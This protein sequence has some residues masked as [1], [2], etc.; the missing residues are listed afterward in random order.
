MPPIAMELHSSRYMEVRRQQSLFEE[1]AHMMRNFVVQS[2]N[3][4]SMKIGWLFLHIDTVHLSRHLSNK[5]FKLELSY[6]PG[7]FR[8]IKQSEPV[9]STTA[10]RGQAPVATFNSTFIFVYNNRNNPRDQCVS[11]SLIQVGLVNRTI[12][13][14]TLQLPKEGRSDVHY[15]VIA[16]RRGRHTTP[17]GHIGVLVE[18][19]LQAPEQGYYGYS[20][21]LSIQGLHST[22][23]KAL[24][25]WHEEGAPRV[26][27]GL[28]MCIHSA[29]A[30]HEHE[31]IVLGSMWS[32]NNN[33]QRGF[34]MG[35]PVEELRRPVVRPSTSSPEHL[36]V[37][38]DVFGDVVSV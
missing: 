36:R 26:V 19:Q 17:V 29:R 34:T 1:G 11:I 24:A 35:L 10:E 38:V 5:D 6:R 3:N 22:L 8:M 12:A 7:D 16:F 9:R 27:L 28:P 4:V 14:A 23:I 37:E 21:G 15:K 25:A 2:T 20:R 33:D 31:E 13:E 32:M 30:T 18:L